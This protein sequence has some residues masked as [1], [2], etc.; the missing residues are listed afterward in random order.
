MFCQEKSDMIFKNFSTN[1]K[2]THLNPSAGRIN[3]SDDRFLDNQDFK[4][5]LP[6]QN[7]ALSTGAD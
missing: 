7:F 3:I 1:H 2:N 5:R 4:G 6:V